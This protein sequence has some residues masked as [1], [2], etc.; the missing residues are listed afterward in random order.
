MPITPWNWLW[1]LTTLVLWRA[2]RSK[3]R[4]RTYLPPFVA[5]SAVAAAVTWSGVGGSWHV[6]LFPV[7]PLFLFGSTRLR[8]HTPLTQPSSAGSISVA[9]AR[10]RKPESTR[11]QRAPKVRPERTRNPLFWSAVAWAP[12]AVTAIVLIAVG[13]DQ[14]WVVAPVFPAAPFLTAGLWRWLAKVAATAGRDVRR[15]AAIAALEVSLG[16]A[17]LVMPEPVPVIINMAGT[18]PVSVVTAG[19]PSSSVTSIVIGGQA[20]LH[21]EVIGSVAQFDGSTDVVPVEG[22]FVT[23]DGAVGSAYFALTDASGHVSFPVNPGTY[24]VFVVPPGNRWLVTR[25]CSDLL[26]EFP[27][28]AGEQWTWRVPMVDANAAVAYGAV[29]RCDE[30]EHP[31]PGKGF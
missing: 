13:V 20:A 1:T 19:T 9:Y 23:L 17:G 27:V 21:I 7:F 11:P 26:E 30:A 16:V 10:P 5:C 15:L 28:G 25:G 8:F 29:S 3:T 6:I 22:A 4:V 14:P 12:A 18:R 2:A 24:T 31:T